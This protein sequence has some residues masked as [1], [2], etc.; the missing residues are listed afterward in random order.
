[1]M[2]PNNNTVERSD[3]LTMAHCVMPPG[4]RVAVMGAGSG[5]RCAKYADIKPRY[6][7]IGL[8]MR[9]QLIS[10]ARNQFSRPNLQFE[11][12]DLEDPDLSHLGINGIINA[13][14][15]HQIYSKGGY[16]KTR[17]LRSLRRQVRELPVG[18]LL[19]IHDRIAPRDAD[20]LVVLDL[21]D[22][23]IK[24][25]DPAEM[26][27]PDLLIDYSTTARPLES[28]GFEGFFLE[29]ISVDGPD[30]R[31]F[32][33]PLKWAMEFMYRLP[34]RDNWADQLVTE[35]T[36]M[37]VDDLRRELERLDLR[38]TYTAPY[39][40]P[41]ILTPEFREQV[42]LLDTDGN[43]FDYP[44]TSMAI[45]AHKV[46]DTQTVLIREKRPL[47]K[48]GENLITQRLKNKATGEKHTIVNPRQDRDVILPYRKTGEGQ[49]DVLV[50][51]EAVQPLVNTVARSTPNLDGRQ[52]S[53]HMVEPLVLAE[54]EGETD[55][56]IRARI[57]DWLADQFDLLDDEIGGIEEAF[58]L[59]PA[60]EYV[61]VKLS[62]YLVEITTGRP[63]GDM[64]YRFF[65]ARDILKAA[66]VGVLPDNRLEMAIQ[67]LFDQLELEA[68]DD[69]FWPDIALGVG[70]AGDQIE[71]FEELREFL[72]DTQAEFEETDESDEEGEDDGGDGGPRNPVETTRSV[73]IEEGRIDGLPTGLN[74]L[75]KEFVRPGAES[76]NTIMV[77]PLN[78]DAKGK[79]SV[80]MEKRE[81]PVPKRR[82]NT[83]SVLS[84]PSFQLPSTVKTLGQARKYIAE[85]LEI[86][87]ENLA[88]LGASYYPDLDLSTER[89]YPFVASVSGETGDAFPMMVPWD[90]LRIYDPACHDPA[91]EKRN[92]HV[93]FKGLKKKNINWKA[94]IYLEED[95]VKRALTD[96]LAEL[97]R[98]FDPNDLPEEVAIPSKDKKASSGAFSRFINLLSGEKEEKEEEKAP[99]KEHRGPEPG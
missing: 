8:D 31:R 5:E 68:D 72:T 24:S 80:G 95:R 13:G 76:G 77:V 19:L 55:E 78:K 40:D 34:T 9:D 44:P 15:L 88:Q 99:K 86:P 43:P 36:F 93:I 7:I 16:S 85:K 27:M 63:I 33:L 98:D 64:A 75:E 87:E 91:Y 90:F 38:L 69:P 17:I 57:H 26:G 25:D 35:Y 65:D 50:R 92:E 52:W 30:R 60:P 67:H 37:A 10:Q 84:L 59:Y 42:K 3:A 89:V 81:L 79:I 71:S 32:R 48:R 47:S 22:I 49:I 54:E 2:T 61:D 1:M 6:Q 4:S 21:A 39:W 41:G 94:D 83:D 96:N 62:T 56:Q 74:S 82:S 97:R 58:E 12:V 28:R 70:D 14:H 66:E 73:F 18:G 45:I 23:G 53:G 11:A 51:S 29:E 20:Q 46:R